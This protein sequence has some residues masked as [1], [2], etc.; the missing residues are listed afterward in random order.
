LKYTVDASVAAAWLIPGESFEDK[1]VKLRDDFVEGRVE[2]YA[3]HLLVFELGNVLWKHARAGKM[4][5]EQAVELARVMLDILPNLVDLEEEDL[6]RAMEIATSEGVTFY[7]AS[8]IAVAAKTKSTLVTADRK[9]YDA[10]R[11]HA[12]ALM[13]HEYQP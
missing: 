12:K 4:S 8:Y 3:P 7:D 1:A 2:L 10:A 6:K 11:K 9:L 5:A 13:I